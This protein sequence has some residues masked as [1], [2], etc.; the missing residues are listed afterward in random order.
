M[1][2]KRVSDLRKV[3][4]T[5]WK[6]CISS[7]IIA[8]TLE[9][10]RKMRMWDNGDMANKSGDTDK[11]KQSWIGLNSNTVIRFIIHY[12]KVFLIFDLLVWDKNAFDAYYHLFPIHLLARQIRRNLIPC[13]N[14][15]TL[16]LGNHSITWSKSSSLLNEKNNN[17][18]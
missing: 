10:S 12:H 2:A 5:F 13:C 3:I 15:E 11:H 16:N 9:Y 18:L 17:W 4:Y 14:A 8:W 7:F 1:F 6:P